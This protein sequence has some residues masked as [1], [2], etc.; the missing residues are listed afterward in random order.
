VLCWA[1]QK[2]E[3]KHEVFYSRV[4]IELINEQVRLFFSNLDEVSIE[5]DDDSF[6][7]IEYVNLGLQGTNKYYKLEK[8]LISFQ[9]NAN[10]TIDTQLLFEPPQYNKKVLHHVYNA[11]NALLKDIQSNAALNKQQEL[12]LKN[13][14]VT[15]LICYFNG[16]EDAITKLEEAKPHLRNHSHEVYLLYKEAIRILR[17]IKY[18]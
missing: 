1:G 15:Y 9:E 10:Y 5:F 8:T 2:K 12:D 3:V 7:I 18:N 17:K 4:D 14:P 11:N 13:L 16:F 6:K